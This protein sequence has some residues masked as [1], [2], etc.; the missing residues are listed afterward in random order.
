MP[1][2][3]PRDELPLEVFLRNMNR[4]LGVSLSNEGVLDE[5]TEETAL[6]IAPRELEGRFGGPP[7]PQLHS[8]ELRNVLRVL[9]EAQVT[10]VEFGDQVTYRYGW[11]QVLNVVNWYLHDEEVFRATLILQRNGWPQAQIRD[12]RFQ[13]GRGYWSR[14]SSSGLAH[15]IDDWTVVILL[16]ISSVGIRLYQTERVPSTFAPEYSVR[17]PSLPQYVAALIDFVLAHRVG[18]RHLRYQAET[19]LVRFIFVF[20][21]HG[22]PAHDVREADGCILP[23][24]RQIEGYERRV[25]AARSTVRGWDWRGLP[26]EYLQILDRAI[27]DRD[28][29]RA[30]NSV[31]LRQGFGLST[32]EEDREWL[33]IARAHHGLSEH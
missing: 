16:P 4:D 32:T 22:E 8:I 11:P 18:D 3:P 2:Q 28:Y 14:Q 31:P 9:V 23:P 12:H 33:G 5:I 25:A 19:D 10:L 26:P 13:M 21:L 6:F 29:I 27:L 1:M 7:G 30:L 17:T 20:L 15:F 24:V